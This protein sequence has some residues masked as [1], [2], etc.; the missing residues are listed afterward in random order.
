MARRTVIVGLVVVIA[1]IAAIAARASDVYIFGNVSGRVAKTRDANVAVNWAFKCLGDKLGE[2][3]Y[4]YTLIAV[5]LD[6]TPE[7][8]VT[9]TS[10]TSKK[11]SASV[12]LSAGS[13][14]LRGDPFLCE[15]ER[16]AGSTN[17]E[18]GAVVTVPD[19]CAWTVDKAKAGTT[20]E[21]AS[22]VKA[23]KAGAAVAPG[24]TV[25]TASGAATLRTSGK[26]AVLALSPRTK[27][28]IDRRQCYA[29]AGWR[30]MVPSGGVDA[31]IKSGP[32]GMSNHDVATPNAVV[33]AK[34]ARFTVVTGRKAG[35]PTTAVR[36]RSGSVVVVGAGGGRVTVK[37]GLS[38]SVAGSA[39]PLKPTK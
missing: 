33:T 26:D 21:T 29:K 14:Q 8:R 3:K 31:T 36:V 2:A 39:R 19:Y 20:L 5:R 6:P 32:D 24:T 17:P 16:G 12:R 11:G 22:S 4:E 18:I 10:D 30:V 15:T 38:T 7:K 25:V 1:G 23:A 9:I 37:A 13:W 35:S 28:T 34:V 27:A